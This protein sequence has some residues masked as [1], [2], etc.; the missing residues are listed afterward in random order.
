MGKI[1]FHGY[2]KE[3]LRL[4]IDSLVGNIRLNQS[5]QVLEL[6]TGEGPLKQFL[7]RYIKINYNLNY[8]EIHNNSGTILVTID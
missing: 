1:D 4:K 2:T 8:R 7:I 5:C 3:E 6:V